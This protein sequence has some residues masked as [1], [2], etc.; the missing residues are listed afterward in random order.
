MPPTQHEYDEQQARLER[1]ELKQQQRDRFLPVLQ[2]HEVSDNVL[3]LAT[4]LDGF[5]FFANTTDLLRYFDKPWKWQREYELYQ[6]WSQSSDTD[7]REACQT[8]AAEETTVEAIL[9]A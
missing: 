8:A 5:C 2:W 1:E 3:G 4:W 7:E 9:N 6:R